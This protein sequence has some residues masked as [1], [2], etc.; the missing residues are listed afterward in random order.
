[1]QIERYRI[2]SIENPI[3]DVKIFRLQSEDGKVLRFLP[4]QFVFIHLLDA[5]GKSII[6]RPYSIASS[7]SDPYLE[8]GIEMRSGDMT[9]RLDKLKA[10]EGVGVEGPFGKMALTQE[11][12]AAF[13]AGGVGITP[14]MSMIRFIC[15]KK[16]EGSFVLFYSVRSIDKILYKDELER[17]QKKNPALKV[18]ITITR[19][20]PPDWIG[21]CGRISKEMIAKHLDKASETEWFLCGSPEM[22]KGVRSCLEGLGVDQKKIKMEGWG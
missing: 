11:K 21:E 20:T 13:I 16:A 5:E 7:P 4:G 1:M 14:F 10:G 2:E 3:S 17:L 9:K 6:K 19:E 15:V 8:F 22:V 18:V 12:K